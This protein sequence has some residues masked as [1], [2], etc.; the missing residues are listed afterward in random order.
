MAELGCLASIPLQTKT[1]S[2]RYLQIDVYGVY[3]INVHFFKHDALGHRN[4]GAAEGLLEAR[5]VVGFG[6][7]LR[8]G[9]VQK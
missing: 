9:N 6:V 5:N 4:G 7:L 1:R 8:L 2:I 3:Q